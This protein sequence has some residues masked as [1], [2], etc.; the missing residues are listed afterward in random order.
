MAGFPEP[1]Q[2]LI[3]ELRKLPGIGTRS[4]ERLALYLLKAGDE[5]ALGLAKAIEAVKVV[6]RPCRECLGFAEDALCEICS[7]P[8]RDRGTIMVVESPKDLVAF[9]RTG[10][11]RGVYHV[12]LGHVSPH[13]GVSPGHL[14]LDRLVER[15]RSGEVREI[16][17]ATN[18]DAEGDGT[19][20]VLARALEDTGVPVTRLARGLPSGWTIEYAGTEILSDAL[21][22]RRAQPAEEMRGG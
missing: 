18:P 13:E 6:L 4:A 16:I 9:E 11:Y 2:H 10:R 17:L 19:A 15:A 3:D 5:E 20:L 22:G 1:L 8:H 12:L 21:E 7:D 14:G